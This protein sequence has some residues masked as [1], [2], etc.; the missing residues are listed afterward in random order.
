MV[1]RVIRIILATRGIKVL[2]DKRGL[3]LEPLS[4]VTVYKT[5]TR[6]YT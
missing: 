2:G 5:Y 3:E 6:T 1:T 4:F